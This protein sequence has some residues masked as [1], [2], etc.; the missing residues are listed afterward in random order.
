MVRHGSRHD[1]GTIQRVL[2]ALNKRV[3][4]VLR[5]LGEALANVLEPSDRLVAQLHPLL[6]RDDLDL[7]G[8]QEAQRTAGPGNS[9][10]QV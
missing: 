4:L 1:D 5:R 7:R 3:A 6:G 9:V 10:E 2:Q 8:N